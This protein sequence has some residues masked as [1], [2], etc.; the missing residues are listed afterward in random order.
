[1]KIKAMI[2]KIDASNNLMVVFTEDRRFIKLP[3][4]ANVPNLGAA[5]QVDSQPEK[6]LMHK[7]LTTKWFTVAAVL[8]LVLAAGLYSTLGVSPVSAYVNLDM[9][10]RM[11]LAVNPQGKVTGVTALNEEARQLLDRVDTRRQDLYQVI[12]DLMEE[13]GKQGYLEAQ[14]QNLVMVS[15]TGVQDSPGYQIDENTLRTI[16]KEVL[17]SQH[18][19]GYIVVNNTGLKEWQRARQAGQTINEYLVS[20]RAREKGITLTPRE[21]DERDLMQVLEKSNLPVPTLFPENTWEVPRPGELV[22]SQQG[23][24][25]SNNSSAPNQIDEENRTGSFRWQQQNQQFHDA[26][27][28]AAKNTTSQQQPVWDKDTQ[29]PGNEPVYGN[30]SFSDNQQVR[31]QM[32]KDQNNLLDNENAPGISQPAQQEQQ[33]YDSQ[34]N[35]T[36]PGNQGESSNHSNA[37]SNS[38]QSGSQGNG[39]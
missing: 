27:A 21:L 26:P 25:Q 23:E 30:D 32:N 38:R 39:W 14:K 19:S 17:I 37:E 31:E 6:K 15:V 4:P 5:I 7:I 16:I 2:T 33:D 35:H 36:Q 1:M 29:S 28:P 24:D 9:K 22:P 20:E 12:N 10:P 13:A 11:Q 3:L 18:L 34:T 8:L